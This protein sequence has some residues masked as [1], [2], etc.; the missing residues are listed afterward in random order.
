[1]AKIIAGPPKD[2][3]YSWRNEEKSDGL[4]FPEIS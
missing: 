1:M 3:K 2:Q 4:K